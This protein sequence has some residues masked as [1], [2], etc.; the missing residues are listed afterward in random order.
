MDAIIP[1]PLRAAIGPFALGWCRLVQYKT[2]N[3]KGL[4][5]MAGVHSA[6]I[7]VFADRDR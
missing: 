2:E 5:T 3:A 7:L 6:M 1:S 4:R